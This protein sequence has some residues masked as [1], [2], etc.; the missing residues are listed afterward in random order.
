MVNAVTMN[1]ISINVLPT[2]EKGTVMSMLLRM[3]LLWKTMLKIFKD[4]D[5]DDSVM[6]E[7]L[8][9]HKDLNTVPSTHIRTPGVVTYNPLGSLVSSLA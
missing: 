5:G 7:G 2:G 6:E 3:F 1:A 4:G 8:H 9:L